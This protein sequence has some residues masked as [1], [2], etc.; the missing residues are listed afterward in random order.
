ME[1][2]RLD[3]TEMS[4]KFWPKQNI[5]IIYLMQW[6]IGITESEST[7]GNVL[8]INSQILF[9]FSKNGGLNL[10]YKKQEWWKVVW[11]DPFTV[12][13]RSPF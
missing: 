6:F 2:G 4:L 10:L 8:N 11:W 13:L 9:Y 5:G 3:W 12:T 7:S 1:N